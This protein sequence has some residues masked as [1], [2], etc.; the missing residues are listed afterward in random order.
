MTNP[1]LT[2]GPIVLQPAGTSGGNAVE[3][4]V[5]DILV[6]LTQQQIALFANDQVFV[7]FSVKFPGSNGEIVRIYTEDYVNIKAYGEFTYHV[8][9][10]EK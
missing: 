2:I 6:E 7:G 1:E 9:P 4:V 5:S 8:D 3:E 10:E